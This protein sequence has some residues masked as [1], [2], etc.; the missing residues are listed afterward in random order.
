M[1]V[2]HALRRRDYLVERSVLNE[3]EL[4][5]IGQRSK[6]LKLPAWRRKPQCLV[7]KSLL[8]RFFPLLSWLP[9]YPVKEWLLGDVVSGLSVGIV[10][11]PQGLAY[12]ML[13][14]LPPVYGL[15]T[16]FYPTLVYFFFGT[17]RHV[18]VGTFAVV[19]V[20][21]G[22]VT[23][24]LVPNDEFLLPG[25]GT[26]TA[27]RDAMRVQVAASL[28]ILV[29]IFQV[30]LGLVQFG[31]VVTYLS[32]PLVRGYTTAA[33]IQ[34]LMS[35]LKYV[36]GVKLGEHSG[37]LSMIYML[38]EICSKLPQT[39][40]GTLLT[41]LI[42]MVILLAVKL[43]NQKF[44]SKLFMPIPIELFTL[45]GA[46]GISFGAK[47]QKNYGVDVVGNIP[48]GLIPPMMP[49]FSLFGKVA[50]N[51]FAIAIVAY[52]IAISLGKIFALKHGYKVDSNQELIA[53]GLSNFLGGFFRCFT[54]SC[55]MSRSLVQESTGGNSQVA[56]AVS[57]LVILIIIVKLGELFSDLP[58][59][60]L[61]AIIIVN[62]K[63]MFKQ[64]SDI[65][66]LWKANRIDL[67]IWLVTF[68][69]TLLLNLDIG[70]GAS[71]AFAL[72]TVIFRTQLPQY[73]IL[74]QV[75]ETD[76]YRDVTEYKEAKELPG[77]KI[78]HSSATLYFANA[79]LY[80]EAL[81]KK[82]GID[83]DH[84]ITKKKKLIKKQKQKQNK[85]E[86]EEK[87]RDKKAAAAAAEIP[88]VPEGVNSDSV[89]VRI[90]SIEDIKTKQVLDK[91]GHES[92]VCVTGDTQDLGTQLEAQEKL[93]L[94]SLGLPRPDFHTLILDFAPVNFVDTVC[95][96]IL[97]NIFGDFREIEVDVYLASCQE[98]V[99][100]QLEAGN[101]F[102]QTITKA[103]VFASVH[104]AVT[105]SLRGRVSGAAEFHVT[106]M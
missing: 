28:T 25:N 54:I 35:Q 73:S 27:T 56:G 45:I 33:A 51:A 30:A 47:L 64:F 58:K 4:E 44:H 101:F 42:A 76:L 96:K 104:D 81:K 57:S 43:L 14:G 46:T 29:G 63:G 5:E 1:E 78:F 39:N 85:I 2:E 105:Y 72:L 90:G 26:V 17:S 53:L 16:S 32:E 94:E 103:H 6:K 106:K 3:E 100:C 83:V 38:I 71:V 34:V 67:M 60:I 41:S 92:T 49:D 10:H 15:Y 50:G 74:G 59:A 19:S 48:T 21:V 98:S 22:S 62:L 11:L 80:A 70:L 65:Q 24:A 31:F 93:T 13:A 52:V 69:S 61:A 66:T 12:A 77:V 102:S 40:V 84:L 8:L 37:P 75:T 88:M 23:E 68:M 7:A 86:K 89:Q 95:I 87:K 97:K 36:F 9:R 20:M 82:C 91:D 55:S 18:S 79:E 99:I